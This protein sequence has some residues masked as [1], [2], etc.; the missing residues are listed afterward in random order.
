[1]IVLAVDGMSCAR[2]ADHI[3]RAVQ[4]SDPDAQVRVD[5]AAGRVTADTVLDRERLVA[6][7]TAAGYDVRA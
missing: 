5:L 4:A 6:A 1:M 2:C 3:L 7:I